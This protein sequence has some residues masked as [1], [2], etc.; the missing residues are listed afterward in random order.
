MSSLVIV[1]Y[2]TCTFLVIRLM[3][4]VPIKLSLRSQLQPCFVGDFLFKY[5]A[6]IDFTSTYLGDGRFE[7]GE[8]HH[9]A[10]S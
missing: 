10:T 6:Y 3:S 7:W 1:L 8:T 9:M 2:I 4:Y 5:S